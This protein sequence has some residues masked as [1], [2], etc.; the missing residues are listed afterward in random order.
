[1]ATL[2]VTDTAVDG[3]ELALTAAAGGGDEFANSGEVF[4]V[5]QNDDASSTTVTFVT[6]GTVQSLAVADVAVTVPAG[7]LHVAGP[8]NKSLFNDANGR[9][10]VTY[11]SVTS[12]TVNPFRMTS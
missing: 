11:S 7:E 5:M 4:F 12:L 2:T 3:V 6:Q 8:F 10:Q 1:M 9:V